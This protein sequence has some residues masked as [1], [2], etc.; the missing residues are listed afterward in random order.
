MHEMNTYDMKKHIRDTRSIP[1]SNRT[2]QAHSLPRWQAVSF[3]QAQQP[4]PQMLKLLSSPSILSLSWYSRAIISAY[5]LITFVS[6]IAMI[7]VRPTC[8]TSARH[9]RST[10][11]LPQESSLI[12]SPLTVIKRMASSSSL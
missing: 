7:Q 5:C 9:R 2:R 8:W 4:L 10:S 1:V 12:I 6:E 11:R 3:R